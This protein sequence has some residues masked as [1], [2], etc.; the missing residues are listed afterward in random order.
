MVFFVIPCIFIE[1]KKILYSFYSVF[2]IL[3]IYLLFFSNHHPKT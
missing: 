1:D 3:Q 2:L